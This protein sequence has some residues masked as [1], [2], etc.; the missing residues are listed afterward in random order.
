MSGTKDDLLQEV[1]N[2]VTAIRRLMAS[3]M[4]QLDGEGNMPAS[5]AELLLIVH[6]EGRPT[7]KELA[8]L[9]Q[10]T[11]GAI[12]QLVEYLERMDYVKRETS[13]VDRRVTQVMITAEGERKIS[14]VKQQKGNLFKHVYKEL[15]VDELRTMNTVQ[16]KMISYLKSSDYKANP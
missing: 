5:Q 1:M 7:L 8:N 10:I 2:N 3:C 11:P 15:T 14:A 16:K 4:H 9:M 13:R 6:Q 12:T